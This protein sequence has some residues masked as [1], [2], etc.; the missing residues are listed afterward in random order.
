[1]KKI[2]YII[3][4]VSLLISCKKT[5]FDD[6]ANLSTE[7]SYVLIK[8]LGFKLVTSSVQ[9]TF[10]TVTSSSGVHFSLLADQT[11]NTNGNSSWWDFANEPRLRLNNNASYRG[12]VTWNTFYN[13]FYQANL[14]ASIALDIIEGQK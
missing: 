9:S 7:E 3:L 14:D 8:D 12:A 6:P 10:N 4:P 11:T 1:M 5:S 13:S 2:F